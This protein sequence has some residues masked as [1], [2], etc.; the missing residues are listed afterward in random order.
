M[1]LDCFITDDDGI[2][3]DQIY[4][5]TDADGAYDIHAADMDSDGDIDIVASSIHD[6]SIRW[7]LKNDGNINP[8]F[9]E[10]TIATDVDSVREITI[11]D[12]DNDGDLDILSASENDDT[13]AWYENNGAADPLFAKADYSHQC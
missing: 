5:T 7:F 3:W 8:S 11:A 12:M 6:D 1:Q 9:A 4:I 13:I 10:T 2:K